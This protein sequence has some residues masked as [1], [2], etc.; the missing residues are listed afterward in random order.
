MNDFSSPSF[1]GQYFDMLH[2][3][4]ALLHPTHPF[5]FML[6]TP[7]QAQAIAMVR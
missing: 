1:F 2:R 6:A 5:A 4:C 7:K 3:P